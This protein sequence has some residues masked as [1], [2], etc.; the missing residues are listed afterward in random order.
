MIIRESYFREREKI[1]F[2]SSFHYRGR[3]GRV[4]VRLAGARFEE[5]NDLHV[6]GEDMIVTMIFETFIHWYH[7]KSEEVLISG[8]LQQCVRLA[9]L[10]TGTEDEVCD[11]ETGG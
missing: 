6:N 7:D 10:L 3:Y 4:S 8:S 1:N 2:H 9:N 5:A 11:D